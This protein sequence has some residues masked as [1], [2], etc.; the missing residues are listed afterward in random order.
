[1][2][3][4]SIHHFRGA[5]KMVNIGKAPIAFAQSNFAAKTYKGAVAV[6]QPIIRCPMVLS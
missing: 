6:E 4:D 1:M 5:T 2:R 3:W